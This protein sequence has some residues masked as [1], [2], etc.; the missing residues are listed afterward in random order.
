MPVARIRHHEAAFAAGGLEPILPPDRAPVGAAGDA[1]VRVVL[2]R[3]I[4]V[5]WERIVHRHV[6]KLCRGLIVLRG[7][8]LAAVSSDAGAA[9]IHVGDSIRIRGINP[10]PV[11][12]AVTRGQ[13]IE[14]FSA[15]H[16]PKEPGVHKV[17]GVR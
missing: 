17:H 13:E 4:N 8:T 11:M 6:V 9:V 1:D 3:A 14:S 2:L 15:I 5:I 10:Q 16:R 7:P 12:I